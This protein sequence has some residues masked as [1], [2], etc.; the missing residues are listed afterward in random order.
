MLGADGAPSSRVNDSK[1]LGRKTVRS[2]PGDEP[3]TKERAYST[4]NRS[5]IRSAKNPGAS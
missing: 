2:E 1:A 4:N 3:L 5:P